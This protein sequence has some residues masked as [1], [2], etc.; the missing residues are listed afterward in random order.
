MSDL[1]GHGGALSSL[2]SRYMGGTKAGG[3]FCKKNVK[4][5]SNCHVNTASDIS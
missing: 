5:G 1:V 2:G 3:G 4:K